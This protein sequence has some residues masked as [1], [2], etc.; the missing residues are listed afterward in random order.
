MSPKNQGTSL[1]Q[2]VPLC[3]VLGN[4][5]LPGSDWILTE[6]PLLNMSS[7]QSLSK[8]L[9]TWKYHTPACIQFQFGQTPKIPFIQGI[10]L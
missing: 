3:E 2:I 9:I 5:I 7:Q 10:H 6:G 4:W 8:W 1:R